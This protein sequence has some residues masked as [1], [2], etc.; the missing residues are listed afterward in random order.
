MPQYAFIQV[1]AAAATLA[2]F[3][4]VLA[5]PVGKHAGARAGRIVLRVS[6]VA[7][8]AVV[9]GC[10]AWGQATGDLAAFNT[11]MGWEAWLQIGV[12]FLLILSTGRR[13]VSRYLDDLAASEHTEAADA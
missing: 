11:R 12:F 7:L 1:I 13:F 3:G 10:L 6:V 4:I 5:I 8:L 9:A 2:L